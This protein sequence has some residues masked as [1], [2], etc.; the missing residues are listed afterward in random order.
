MH[1]KST[2]YF[3]FSFSSAFAFVLVF[4]FFLVTVNFLISLRNSG[5]VNPP[6]TPHAMNAPKMSPYAGSP[7]VSIPRECAGAFF[8]NVRRAGDQRNTNVCNDPS[9]KPWIRPILDI[10]ESLTMVLNAPAAISFGME[11]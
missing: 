5:S 2:L 4:V 7:S 6:R 9:V 3:P 1:R 8:A 10:F 11:S